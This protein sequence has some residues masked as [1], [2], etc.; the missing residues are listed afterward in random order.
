[1]SSR[2]DPPTLLLEG[3]DP[4]PY[5]VVNG[6]GEGGVV[7]VCDHASHRVPRRLGTLGLDVA[8]LR[9]HIGWDPGAAEVARHLSTEL[10]AP[11]LKSSALEGVF[12]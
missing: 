7:L 1:M 9:A 4:P 6:D 11:Q 12:L 3:D 5:E 8:R 2:L 10:D